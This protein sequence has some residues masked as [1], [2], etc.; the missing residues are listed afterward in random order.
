[1]SAKF[2][3]LHVSN[4]YRFTPQPMMQPGFQISNDGVWTSYNGRRRR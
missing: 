2:P 1:M 3:Y 4:T